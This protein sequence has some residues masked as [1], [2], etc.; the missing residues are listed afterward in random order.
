MHPDPRASAQPLPHNPRKQRENPAAA[1]SRERFRWGKWRRRR[2]S[3]PRDGFPPTPLAGER[4]RP[5]GHVSADAYIQANVWITRQ[6]C[7]VPK[8]ALNWPDLPWIA[9]SHDARPQ[10]RR[11]FGPD[12]CG[13]VVRARPSD[14]RGGGCGEIVCGDL[15]ARGPKRRRFALGLSERIQGRGET[16][17]RR[18]S[19]RYCGRDAAIEGRDAS[20]ADDET[21]RPRAVAAADRP[22]SAGFGRQVADRAP[23]G[24]DTWMQPG[25][26]A[27]RAGRARIP[28]PDLAAGR[29]GHLFAAGRR[30]AS[31]SGMRS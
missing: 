11:R 2:D 24:R 6:N 25:D 4:L 10:R 12:H 16:P 13:P 31:R 5:L 19:G 27:C 26:A 9:P 18:T 7:P 21:G 20:H 30:S 8:K 1:G 28:G 3:N 17:A 22:R 14:C 15:L 29:P 23:H